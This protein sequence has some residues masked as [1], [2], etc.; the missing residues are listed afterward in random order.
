MVD[1]KLATMML[2]KLDLM[3]NGKTITEEAY[4]LLKYDFDYLI[5]NN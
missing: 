3:L 2:K 5:K 4:K 1:K